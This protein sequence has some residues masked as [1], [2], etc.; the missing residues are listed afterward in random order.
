MKREPKA[1]RADDVVGG[2]PLSPRE[3]DAL[4]ALLTA[5]SGTVMRSGRVVVCRCRPI[6]ARVW[7]GLVA[8]GL[9]WGT[10]GRLY[11]TG[12]GKRA[13]VIAGVRDAVLER[14]RERVAA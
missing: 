8:R 13:L 14:E 4:R 9:V 6:E 1:S 2:C 10:L 11:V 7:L 3:R 12:D 5:G